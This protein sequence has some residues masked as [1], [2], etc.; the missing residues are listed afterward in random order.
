MNSTLDQWILADMF[1]INEYLPP[2]IMVTTT[3]RKTLG[4]IFDFFSRQQ[5]SPAESFYIRAKN[6]ESAEDAE[7]AEKKMEYSKEAPI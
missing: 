6:A 4:P 1:F 7:D 3:P 5:T 2:S